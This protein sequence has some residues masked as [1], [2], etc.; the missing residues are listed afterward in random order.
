MASDQSP[1][2]PA[3]SGGL[4]APVADRATGVGEHWITC[5]GSGTR[6]GS[7]PGV[8]GWRL[9]QPVTGCEHPRKK[10]HSRKVGR[11]RPERRDDALSGRSVTKQTPWQYLSRPPPRRKQVYKNTYLKGKIYVGMELTG[12]A[13]H[14]GRPSAF[15]QIATDH[16]TNRS[17]FTFRLRKEILWGS[18]TAT[19]LS[20]TTR[21]GPD[22]NTPRPIPVADYAPSDISFI[23][24]ITMTRVLG[25]M[26]S[27][28]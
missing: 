25:Q 26:R 17:D 13:L 10:S 11:H 8:S 19:E 3:P 15:D 6:C 5:H 18:E 4:Q 9:G 28:S 20:S 14:F 27:A 16:Q 24:R 21:S 22:A 1:A 12:T 7:A 23:S 2:V